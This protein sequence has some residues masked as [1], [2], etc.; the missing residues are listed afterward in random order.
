MKE[1]IGQLLSSKFTIVVVSV[2]AVSLM[3]T[4]FEALHPHP[5]I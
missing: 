5:H 2:I 3:L 4:G 1:L